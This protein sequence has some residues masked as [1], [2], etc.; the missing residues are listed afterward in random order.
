MLSQ[1]RFDS[2]DR[3]DAVHMCSWDMDFA[4]TRSDDPLLAIYGRFKLAFQNSPVLIVQ[5]VPMRRNSKKLRLGLSIVC[6]FAPATA[7]TVRWLAIIDEHVHD[8]TFEWVDW[9]QLPY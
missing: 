3:S 9:L 8:A 2:L 6:R 1:H 5:L 7:W 4:I